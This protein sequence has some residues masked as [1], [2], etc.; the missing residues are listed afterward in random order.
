MK[1]TLF[2]GQFFCK[3]VARYQNFPFFRKNLILYRLILRYGAQFQE[4]DKS[5]AILKIGE[6]NR[7]ILK[8]NENRQILWLILTGPSMPSLKTLFITVHHIMQWHCNHWIGPFAEF[9]IDTPCYM[10][11]Q[12]YIGNFEGIKGPREGEFNVINVVVH[13]WDL[14][15]CARAVQADR[16]VI[17]FSSI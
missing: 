15:N 3:I 10:C 11:L 17:L 2:S 16:L 7:C 12:R 8:V 4:I 13:L 6:E 1:D 5:G 9:T 14:P